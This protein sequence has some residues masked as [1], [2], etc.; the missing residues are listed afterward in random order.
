MHHNKP[1]FFD[2]LKTLNLYTLNL[3]SI[4]LDRVCQHCQSNQQWVSHGFVYKKAYAG[5]KETVGKRVLCSNRGNKQ[6]CGHTVRL[7]LSHRTPNKQYSA[8]IIFLF[9]SLSVISSYSIHQAYCQATGADSSRNAYRWINAIFSNLYQY[10]SLLHQLP[11]ITPIK[12]FAST[13]L[14]LIHETF[15]LIHQRFPSA[16]LYQSF[17]QLNLIPS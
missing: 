17:Y 11:L 13:R 15:S 14:Q 9:L 16:Q 5:N 10:R 8:N 2:S 12:P 4:H 7:Y 1:I 3:G 6:G